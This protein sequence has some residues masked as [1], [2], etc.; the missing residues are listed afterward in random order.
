MK[1][2]GFRQWISSLREYLDDHIKPVGFGRAAH[3][4]LFRLNT[5]QNMALR[6]PLYI[7]ASLILY[8][9]TVHFFLADGDL[10]QR[11]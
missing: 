11:E 7:A 9:A 4:R 8:A 10:Q 5:A 6:A 2:M 1:L 3:T